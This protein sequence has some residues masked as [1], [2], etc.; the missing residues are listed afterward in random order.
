MYI[1][2]TANAGV[3]IICFT[4]ALHEGKEFPADSHDM[5]ERLPA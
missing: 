1:T 3:N 2:G 4:C 5:R